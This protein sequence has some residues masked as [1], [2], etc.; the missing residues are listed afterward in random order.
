[1]E[2]DQPRTQASVWRGLVGVYRA[3]RLRDVQTD[4]IRPPTQAA[5]SADREQRP[6]TGGDSAPAQRG[7][8]GPWQLRV[9]ATAVEASSHTSALVSALTRYA[10]AERLKHERTQERVSGVGIGRLG[11]ANRSD[12]FCIAGASM[13][14]ASP[15]GERQSRSRA[16]VSG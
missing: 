1:M 6:A 5:L 13:G 11:V 14:A 8:S 4:A 9:P 3:P 15:I 16:V 12:Q 10:S 7:G 2:V